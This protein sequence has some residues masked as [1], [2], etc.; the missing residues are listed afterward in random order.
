MKQLQYLRWDWLEVRDGG[1]ENA[2]LIGSRLCGSSLP[3]VIT[4]TGNEL[5]VRFHSDGSVVS[6]GYRI[7]VDLGRIPLLIQIIMD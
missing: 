1:N 7:R 5:F 2:P 3:G 6:T 4:S